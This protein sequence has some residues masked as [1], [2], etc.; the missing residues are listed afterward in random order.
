MLLFTTSK[1]SAFMTELHKEHFK[2]K[3]QTGPVV[4]RVDTFIQRINPYPVDKI[5]AFLILIRQRA[6][7][8]H[9]IAIYPL[10]KVN[11]SSYNRALWNN[12]NK[13]P[14]ARI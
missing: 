1:H 12:L 7:F 3:L 14:V 9:W 11:H 6:N 13:K 4:R 2:I 10:D 8:I 5:G